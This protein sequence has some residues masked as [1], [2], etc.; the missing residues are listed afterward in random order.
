MEEVYVSCNTLE[1]WQ[2]VIR[3]AS[4]AGKFFND[5]ETMLKLFYSVGH[6]VHIHK[7]HH[8]T[9][10]SLNFAREQE[11]RIVSAEKYLG[12]SVEAGNYLP[13]IYTGE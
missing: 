6:C 10:A 2:A 7:E 12:H 8:L 1:E 5:N 4:E 3:S 11:I 13:W 9:H